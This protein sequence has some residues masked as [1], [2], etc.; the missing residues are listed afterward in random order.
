MPH[1]ADAVVVCVGDIHVALGAQRQTIRVIESGE[2][3]GAP[4]PDG[5][6]STTRAGEGGDDAESVHLSMN[7]PCQA[8]WVFWVTMPHLADA[9]V[10]S[11]RD[12]YVPHRRRGDI[13]RRV[14]FGRR[15]GATIPRVSRPDSPRE[16]D[17]DAR[18]G[19]LHV[20]VGVW[21]STKRNKI[22]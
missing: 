9:V 6:G 22:G 10:A 7:E 13:R 5:P 8:G 20:K 16:G 3:G 12:I 18:W 15:G 4:I 1:L 14:Q 19:D 2:R 21:I 11:V 17:H